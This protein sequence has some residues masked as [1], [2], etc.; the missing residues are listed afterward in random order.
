VKKQ[1]LVAAVAG[2]LMQAAMAGAS[3]EDRL[4]QMEQRLYDMEQRLAA[5]DQA[6]REKDKQIAQLTNAKPSS[7]GGG[8]WFN[9]VEVGGLVEVE[10]GHTSADGTSDTSDIITATAEIAINAQ[11]NDWVSTEIVALYEEDTDNA[12]DFGIDTAVVK[13]ANPDSNWFVNAGQFTLPFGIYETNLVSDPITLD[14]GETS[15]SAIEAGFANGNFGASA[16]VFQGDHE[17]DIG[18]FGLALNANTKMDGISLNSH[19]GYISN[20]AESDVIVDDGWVNASS[21]EAAAWIAFAS[22][23]VGDFTLIGE[24]LKAVD[25]FVDAGNEEPAA[26]NLEAAYN[27]D[28]GAK[29]ATVALAYQGSD[30]A[31][32]TN[33]GLDENRIMLGFAV[34][35]MEGTSLGLEYAQAEDYAGAEADTVTGKLTVGF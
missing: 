20:L 7:A 26:Y 14:L 17:A 19:L 30:D 35:L 22:L 11:I 32:N 12:G 23:G 4:L 24:Y 28:V 3:V 31:E 10:A 2:G 16:Y 34:E 15:D 29:P 9:K 13:I 33:W 25:G 5:Q 27:F 18:N 6:I 21:A 1:L 8:E